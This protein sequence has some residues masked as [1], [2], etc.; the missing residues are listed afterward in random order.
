MTELQNHELSIAYNIFDLLYFQYFPKFMVEA[1]NVV[2]GSKPART[3][4]ASLCV[5]TLA[6]TELIDLVRLS[7]KKGPKTFLLFKNKHNLKRLNTQRM[8]MRRRV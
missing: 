6:A 3:L 2:D 1:S 4:V 8:L 5:I 7:F